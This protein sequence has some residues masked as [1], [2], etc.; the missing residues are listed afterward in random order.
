[1]N[2]EPGDH[3]DRGPT[4]VGFD[5]TDAGFSGRGSLRG[6]DHCTEL[7]RRV[8]EGEG[9]TTGRLDLILVEPD[10]I[11]ELN[12]MHMGHDGPTDV[13]SFPMDTEADFEFGDLQDGDERPPL[14]LGDVVLCPT[15]AERQAPEHCGTVD[16]ELS[17]LIIHGVLHIL[18]HDHADP[19]ETLVMQNRERHH[20]SA[21][22]FS[23]PVSR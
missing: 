1:M 13:L 21:L 9:I 22:G 19:D 5:Q 2:R 11:A 15:V 4:V 8:L 3:P 7:A 18:G 6:L 12:E 10:A 14:H 23:H 17:L 16:A 20:L